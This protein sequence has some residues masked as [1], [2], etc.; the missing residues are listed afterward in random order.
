MIM[1]V[2]LE[3]SKPEQGAHNITSYTVSYRC[4]T[5][6]SHGVHVW[7]DYKDVTKEKAIVPQ[8]S[9]NTIYHFKI[10]SESKAGVGLE[11]NISEPV[12]TK[13]MIPSQPGKPRCS[14][15]N[16]DSIQLEWSK[17]EQ[18]AHNITAYR[19]YYRSD[20]DSTSEWIE[21]R[22][23]GNN[24][25]AAVLYL[26][27]RRTYSFKVQPEYVDGVGSISDISEPITT[28]MMI[29]SKPGKPRAS[30][31][32]HNSIELEWTKPE[33][34]AHNVINYSVFYCMISVTADSVGYHLLDFQWRE[35][36]CTLQFSTVTVCNL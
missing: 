23:E 21:Q 24:E 19:V 4:T 18:G 33:Q 15:V 3:W 31:V 29:P 9:E 26:L 2:Q 10:T 14:R 28:K 32:T 7:R 17:P 36:T 5:N 6:D 11:S 27:E 34:G 8:L 13:L 12:R 1:H 20:D 25:S 16:H 22:I 35:Q 30:K